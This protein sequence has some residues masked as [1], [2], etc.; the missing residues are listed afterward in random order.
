MAQRGRP[1][2]KPGEPVK[3]SK[4]RLEAERLIE[5]ALDK[6]KDEEKRATLAKRMSKMPMSGYR[7]NALSINNAEEGAISKLIQKNL[8]V[9]Q[10]PKIDLTDVNQVEGRI[11]EY[12]AIENAYNNRPT[13]SG[14]AMCLNGMDRHGIR[15]IVT[16]NF[17]NTRGTIT[18]LPVEVTALIK[19]YYAL[20]TNLWEDYM[21]SGQINP[22]SGIFLGKN[23]F[24]YR[25]QTEYIVTPNTAP[26]YNESEIR[27]RL[28]LEEPSDSD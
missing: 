24:G 8:M 10:L 1:R 4:E 14:L 25:D 16:G 15:E 27:E 9:A 6:E 19:K 21:Q 3:P 17:G 23:N 11:K 12:L 22:V 28:S 5:A 26:E 7:N 13:V 20:L 2:K 18:R